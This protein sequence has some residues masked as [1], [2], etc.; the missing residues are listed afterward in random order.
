MPPWLYGQ[1]GPLTRLWCRWLMSGSLERIK[2]NV[3][4]VRMKANDSR[5][6]GMGTTDALLF[7]VARPLFLRI[8]ATVTT[9][10]M[11]AL[12]K[13]NDLRNN[14]STGKE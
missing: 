7:S 6:R 8:S 14:G 11:A 5:F 13:I 1:A 10:P 9:V 3:K 12:T 4:H 2:E